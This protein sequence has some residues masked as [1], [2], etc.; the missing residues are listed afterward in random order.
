MKVRNLFETTLD[1]GLAMIRKN[2]LFTPQQDYLVQELFIERVLTEILEEDLFVTY[3]NQ[4]E[5]FDAHHEWVTFRSCHGEIFSVSFDGLM[6][7]KMHGEYQR[8]YL[9]SVL[10]SVAKG[11]FKI[12]DPFKIVAS[13]Q[14]MFFVYG[15]AKTTDTLIF[16]GVTHFTG[17][18]S[19]CSLTYAP[20]CLDSF[21]LNPFRLNPSEG[22]L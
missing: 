19:N 10:E 6:R 4:C 16:K 5:P 3:Q 9:N 14:E 2:S 15:K 13:T 22:V 1:E 8:F 21:R 20:R 11:G 12:L 17:K 18:L 7:Q